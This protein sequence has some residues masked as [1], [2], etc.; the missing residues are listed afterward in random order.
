MNIRNWAYLVILFFLPCLWLCCANPSSAAAE[1]P[2]VYS[3]NV[4]DTVTA[5]TARHIQ[6][7]LE[8]AEKNH[9][10]AVVIL[11]NTPGGLV[12]A[13]LD[14]LQAMS[15]SNV[16]VITYVN[17]Q[18]AIAASAGVFIL[19]NGHIAAMSPGTTC[20]AAM[21]VI[22]PAPGEATQAADQKTI[23]FLAGHMK[24]IAGERGRPADLAEKF[25]TEN[26]TLDNN[27]AL[28]KGVVDFNAANLNELLD[29]TQGAAA[30]TNAGSISLNTSGASVT[31]IPMNLSEQVITIVSNPTTAMIL[32]MLGIYG[33]I[34][35]FYS[36]GFFLPEI[37]GSISLILGLAGMGL[38]QGNLAAGLLILLGIGLLIAEF[39]TPTYGVLGVGG[40][41]SLVLGIL[42]FPA[43]PLMPSGWFSMFKVL[44]FGTG[45]VGAV[46]VSIVVLGISRIRRF[47]PVH[48][49]AEFVNEQ[50]V[51]ISELN[52]DGQIRIKGEMWKATSKNG[53]TIHEG[54]KV[55]VLER[56]GLT[57]IV[58]S[59][60]N[61]DT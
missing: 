46:F 58:K 30:R 31:N 48:G 8:L 36:P 22:M 54:E 6:R 59:L 41:I 51:A 24:S 43:E 13:T 44:A 2:I 42:F 12:T 5:G 53:H 56:Q 3:I 49:E 7:G 25:V 27:E 45:I 11:I 1:Q 26:L 17:P 20:G 57:L 34:I 16:P 61:K 29:K 40:V 47:K 10:D 9:A 32:L 14:I 28:D 50:G 60:D 38:F 18:G 19:I 35:G 4:D 37:L 21:P 39:F 52:P 15:A 23:N 33:L 55:I